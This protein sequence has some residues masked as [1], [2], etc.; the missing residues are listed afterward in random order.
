M[1]TR[2]KNSIDKL[3]RCSSTGQVARRCCCIHHDEWMK[4]NP[5]FDLINVVKDKSKNLSKSIEKK[6]ERKIIYLENLFVPDVFEL[7]KTYMAQMF[8]QCVNSTRKF[9][10][11]KSLTIMKIWILVI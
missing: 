9:H 1:T 10:H 3:E 6:I 8:L 4:D 5:N 7:Q 11:Q 2:S